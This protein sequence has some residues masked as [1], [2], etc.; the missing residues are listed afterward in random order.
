MIGGLQGEFGDL[1]NKYLKQNIPKY[2]KM[3][4]GNIGKLQENTA[5]LY[6]ERKTLRASVIRRSRYV[7]PEKLKRPPL[8]SGY[9][10]SGCKMSAHGIPDMKCREPPSYPD[11]LHPNSLRRICAAMLSGSREHHVLDDNIS[12]PDMLSGWKTLT[13]VSKPCYNPC[14]ATLRWCVR[15]SLPWIPKNSPQ[16]RIALVI[17]KLSKHQNLT[18]FD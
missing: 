9:E 12:Y 1:D 15:T 18:Q 5:T 3:S 10:I 11:Q 13:K 14:S 7:Y 16:S 4:V 8:L 6:T 2:L 17:K